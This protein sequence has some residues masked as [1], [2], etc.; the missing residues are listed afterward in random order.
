MSA[1]VAEAV[2]SVDCLACSLAFNA[3]ASVPVPVVPVVSVVS[4][5]SEDTRAAPFAAR[6]FLIAVTSV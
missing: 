2:V 1:V 5:V 3:A 6:L 4:V